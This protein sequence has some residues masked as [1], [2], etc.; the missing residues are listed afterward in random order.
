MPTTSHHA[1]RRPTFTAGLTPIAV[2]NDHA[3]RLCPQGLPMKIVNA[4]EWSAFAKAFNAGIDSHLQAFTESQAN[5]C[6]GEALIASCELGLLCRR[7][8]EIYESGD[9]DTG[10]APDFAPGDPEDNV[11]NAARHLR[12][13]IIETLEIEEV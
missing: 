7:L 11:G 8:W 12:S 1:R 9:D 2:I 4:L 3:R 6:T 5:P 13:A 10:D